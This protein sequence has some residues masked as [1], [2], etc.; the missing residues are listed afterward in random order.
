MNKFICKKK[1]SLFVGVDVC[2]P[3]MLTGTIIKCN[4]NTKLDIMTLEDYESKKFK[5]Q[6]SDS[7]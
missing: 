2:V 1:K 5:T 4:V 7:N 6:N 3:R